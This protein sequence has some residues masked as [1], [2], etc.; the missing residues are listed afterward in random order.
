MT[1]VHCS[2][3]TLRGAGLARHAFGNCKFCDPGEVRGATA[4]ICER[5]EATTDHEI[6]RRKRWMAGNRIRVTETTQ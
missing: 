4:P 2:N 5:F 3:W 6:E 1:C